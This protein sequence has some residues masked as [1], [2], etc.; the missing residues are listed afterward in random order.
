MPNR[1]DASLVLRLDASLAAAAYRQGEQS[2]FIAY[3]TAR[4]LD[5]G[6]AGVV[7]TKV[8][9]RALERMF[10]KRQVDRILSVNIYVHPSGREM[11][12]FGEVQLV[13]GVQVSPACGY[14]SMRKG[15]HPATQPLGH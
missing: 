10:S 12:R 2:A 8:L 13:G 5:P 11:R 3:A 6:G 7:P 14:P 4:A 9:R 1:G 15:I